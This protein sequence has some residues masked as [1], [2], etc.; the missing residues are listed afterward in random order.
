MEL[1]NDLFVNVGKET[2]QEK[3]NFY[4]EV[5]EERTKLEP[6]Q[7]NDEVSGVT[8]KE[9]EQE[10]KLET[11]TKSLKKYSHE[12]V[13]VKATEYFKGDTLAANV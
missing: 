10:S 12:E 6:T 3:E 4:E 2:E 11:E 13:M 8:T 5:L 7:E 9:P 1:K